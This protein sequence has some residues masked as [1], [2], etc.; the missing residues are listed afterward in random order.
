MADEKKT[1]S[2]S[3]GVT[4]APPAETPKVQTK[5]VLS[6]EE[7]AKG[8]MFKYMWGNAVVGLFPIPVLD[9]FT[10]GG[11]QLVMLKKIS[12]IYDVEFR[13]DI[14]KPLVGAFVGAVGY[15]LL[16]RGICMGLIRFIPPFGLIAGAL[17]F[18]VL[19]AAST[20]AVAKVFIQHFE[21]G[22]TLL[23]LEPSKMK[24]Y[25]ESYYKEGLEVAV[26]LGEKPQD[27]K[28]AGAPKPG[29]GSQEVKNAGTQKS[30]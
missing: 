26:K 28:N 21:A 20:Y 24:K 22:G 29:E 30:K 23:D 8:V 7:Q 12:A 11:V 18:P 14:V 13:H 19:A 3:A 2:A 15:D 16:G 27:E 17:S 25:F 5:E 1:E 6:K 10:V 9:I 4:A